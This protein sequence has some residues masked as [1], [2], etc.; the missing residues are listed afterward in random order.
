MPIADHYIPE[1]PVQDA[2]INILDDVSACLADGQQGRRTIPGN[3]YRH[4]GA[5]VRGLRADLLDLFAKAEAFGL[6]FEAHDR[7]D[8][9]GPNYSMHGTTH[10]QVIAAMYDMRA[11]L[12]KVKP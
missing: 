2:A 9:L 4:I 1:A 11:A 7:G 3:A 5:R 6:L 10:E 8:E 12:Q